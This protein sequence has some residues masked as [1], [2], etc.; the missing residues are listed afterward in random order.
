MSKRNL[1]GSKLKETEDM[2]DHASSGGV[3]KPRG[4]AKRL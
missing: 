3:V 4:A 1:E 2:E